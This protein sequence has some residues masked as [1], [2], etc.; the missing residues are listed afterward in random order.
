[1]R[2]CKEPNLFPNLDLLSPNQPV[3]IGLNLSNI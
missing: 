1:M 2:K 3:F